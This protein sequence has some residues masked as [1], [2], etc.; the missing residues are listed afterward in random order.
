MDAAAAS[1][2]AAV[3]YFLVSGGARVVTLP[4]IISDAGS[5]VP[6]ASTV[7]E[8]AEDLAAYL[9]A[10]RA[11]LFTPDYENVPPSYYRLSLVV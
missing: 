9:W 7:V 3:I 11:E 1:A 4:R 2:A 8:P 10:H 5:G 6:D